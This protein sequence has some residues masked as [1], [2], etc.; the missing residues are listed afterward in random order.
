LLALT[1]LL[2]LSDLAGHNW[3]YIAPPAFKG[4]VWDNEHACVYQFKPAA[5]TAA[6][7]AFEFFSP[8]PCLSD[9]NSGTPRP[10]PPH[11]PPPPPPPPTKG[12]L[13]APGAS[14]GGGGQ[15]EVKFVTANGSFTGWMSTRCSLIDVEDG[16]TW[17][18][19]Y[20][21]HALDC[22]P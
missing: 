13:G 19:M 14:A 22:L 3:T 2:Q 5:G 6:G 9:P 17:E 10:G 18:L 4:G 11:T 16:S 12:T 15:Q 8:K 20:S 21:M 1:P 7:G